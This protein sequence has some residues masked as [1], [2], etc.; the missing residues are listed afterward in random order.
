[1][2]R[3]LI[4]MVPPRLR[5]CTCSGGCIASRYGCIVSCST[6]LRGDRCDSCRCSRGRARQQRGV[7]GKGGQAGRFRPGGSGREV[8]A[9][10][11]PRCLLKPQHIAK[12]GQEG[13]AKPERCRKVTDADKD[14]GNQRIGT[15]GHSPVPPFAEPW[16]TGWRGP[17]QPWRRGF[18]ESL[19]VPGGYQIPE[20]GFRQSQRP[21][22]CL[23]ATGKRPLTNRADPPRPRI[24][25]SRRYCK[26]QLNEVLPNVYGLFIFAS[27]RMI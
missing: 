22:R 14:V 25:P 26:A 12:A 21:R 9:S 1:M 19:V 15:P 4:V 17:Q 7:W 6:L 11:G 20:P 24:G 23:S 3:T 18:P 16:E 2:P 10:R 5:L 8:Q 27:C 13:I